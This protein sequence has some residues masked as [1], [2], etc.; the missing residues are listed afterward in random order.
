MIELQQTAGN[1]SDTIWCLRLRGEGNNL[2]TLGDFSAATGWTAGT[3]WTIGSGV[4]TFLFDS[5]TETGT[6][7][8]TI[9]TETAEYILE[10]EIIS[11]DGVFD[12]YLDSS[13]GIVDS[14]IELDK[15]VGK[16]S[17]RIKC[18]SGTTIKFTYD[19]ANSSDSL[20]IDNIK[21]RKADNIIYLATRNI[22]LDNTYD[23]QVLN[24][25]N[26]LSDILFPS[27]IQGGGGTGT[28]TSFSFSISR[29]VDNDAFNSFFNELYPS[30][31][32]GY[33][34]SRLIDFGICWVGAEADTDITW[35]FRGRVIDYNYEQRRLNFTVFQESEISNKEVP[36]YSVQK[37]F[38]NGISY[39]PD[40]PK[41]SQQKTI[42]VCYGDLMGK[43]PT[44]WGGLMPVV[45]ISENKYLITS[46][47]TYNYYGLAT[48]S[49]LYE[50]INEV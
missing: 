43:G 21:L 47:E 17:I 6:L 38:D 34:V 23:G 46:H 16:H 11:Q 3:G 10:Y 29:Y 33:L 18:N 50:Q 13:S 37:D 1:N 20:V 49:V 7:S 15:T 45:R 8:R 19:G 39:Y 40:A 22:T 44:I 4:A 24:H 48:N 28:V 36:Y 35:L 2:V 42:P 26:Y 32:S 5:P 9:V 30:T 14:D 12:F 41:E 31:D 27:T 25:D